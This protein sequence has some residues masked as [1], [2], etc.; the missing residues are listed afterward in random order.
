MTYYGCH[1]QVVA[2]E[3]GCHYLSGHNI[4][5]LRV[6]AMYYLAA[7]IGRFDRFLPMAGEMIWI[8]IL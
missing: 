2:P 5:Q 1:W 7:I 6:M 3:A 8:K 4:T